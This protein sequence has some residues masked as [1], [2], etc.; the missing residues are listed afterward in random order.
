MLETKPDCNLDQREYCISFQRG[1]SILEKSVATRTIIL[2]F[3][4]PAL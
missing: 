3:A 1:N 2:H 4:C